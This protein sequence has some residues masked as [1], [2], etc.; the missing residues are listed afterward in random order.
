M[1]DLCNS[2]N[3]GGSVLRAL[4]FAAADICTHRSLKIKGKDNQTRAQNKCKV[5]CKLLDRV[6]IGSS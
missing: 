4:N 3:E 5:S 6:D 1:I 2:T